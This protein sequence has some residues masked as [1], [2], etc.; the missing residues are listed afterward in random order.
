MRTIWSAIAPML[1]VGLLTACTPIGA[2]VVSDAPA[3]DAP[4]AAAAFVVE[5]AVGRSVE[6]ATPPSRIVIVGRGTYMVTG[7]TFAFPAAQERVAGFE[8]GRFNDPARFLPFVDPNFDGK[9]ILERNTGPEQVA[10]VRPDAIVLKTTARNELGAALEQLGIPIVYV[11]MESVEQYFNDLTTLGQLLDSPERAQALIGYMQGRL[12]RVASG[13]ADVAEADKP[14]VLVIQ[15]SDEGGEVAFEVPPAS[16]LQTRLVELAGGVPVW[17]EASPGGGW[18]TVNFEQIAQWNP[19]KVVVIHYQA[20]PV[21]TVAALKANPE[22]QALAA[23]Q[24]GEI[25]GFPADT[26]GWDSPDPRWILGLQ[27]LAT[28]LHPDRFADLDIMAEVDS[29]FNE[30]YGMDSASIETNILPAL[31]GDLP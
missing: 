17:T 24:N 15:Y 10:P 29:F 9:I 1:L 25:Y 21:E 23:T 27:W 14:T 19:D 26:F 4:A 11:E 2:P 3:T 22:W 18:A 31:K 6:F 5:D 8:G 28:K 20:D 12:D 30:V 13:L 7:A 16:W